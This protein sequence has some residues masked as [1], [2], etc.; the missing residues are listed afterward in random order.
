MASGDDRSW[1]LTG[2]TS[3]TAYLLELRAVNGVEP[4][5]STGTIVT[6]E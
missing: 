2:L 6:P 3:G 5:Q 4:G 1:T